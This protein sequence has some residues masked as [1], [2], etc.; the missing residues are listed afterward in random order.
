MSA[1]ITVKVLEKNA[2]ERVRISLDRYRGVDLID[3]RVTVELSSSSG[4]WVPTAK[5]LSLRIEQLADLI[6]AL[7]A[8]EAEART[9]GLL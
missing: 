1:P 8:A 3:V 2:R 7:Q 5:G 4:T 6:E 9:R